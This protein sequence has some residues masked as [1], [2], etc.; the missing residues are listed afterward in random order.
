[1]DLKISYS[2]KGIENEDVEGLIVFLPEKS[3]TRAA[4]LSDLPENLKKIINTAVREEVFNGK[5]G[6]SQR[7]ITGSAKPSQLLMIGIGKKEELNPEIIRRAAGGAGKVLACSKLKSI[8]VMLSNVLSTSSGKEC[9]Q[10]ISEGL[11][12]GAYE[13]KSYKS[14]ENNSPKNLKVRIL[15]KDALSSAKAVKLGVLRAVSANIARTLGNTPANDMNPEKLAEEAKNL[16]KTE[17]LK[18]K[19]I[20]EKE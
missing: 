16:C 4:G 7:L 2:S 1:M 12:L 15:D 14:S 17:G 10:W 13:F 3:D 9:G 20:E 11:Q 19:V 5:T 18:Y 6:S 8:G